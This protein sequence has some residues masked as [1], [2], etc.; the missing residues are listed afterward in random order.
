MNK[1]TNNRN[2]IPHSIEITRDQRCSLKALQNRVCHAQPA[3]SG[4]Q[5]HCKASGDREDTPSKTLQAM[6]KSR[7][8]T[9]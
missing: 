2:A 7:E 3:N 6:A 9:F 5:D 1:L 8:I 4:T